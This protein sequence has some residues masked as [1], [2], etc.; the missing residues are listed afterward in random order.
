MDNDPLP[1]AD[2]ILRH[3]AGRH[4]L[5]DNRG[6]DPE[7]F[8]LRHDKGE[9]DLSVNWLEFYKDPI[10]ANNIVLVR[11]EISKARTLKPKDR[12]GK[13]SV[14][15]LKGRLAHYGFPV[16]ILHKPTDPDFPSHSGIF[17][18]ELYHADE[19]TIAAH[20]ASL[21]SEFY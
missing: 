21:T 4:M 15:G 2:H 9:K 20:I 7:A 8:K 18:I 3:C 14:G 17:D 12:L 1:D 5:E 19:D 6:V 16:R 10:L 13:I 11:A